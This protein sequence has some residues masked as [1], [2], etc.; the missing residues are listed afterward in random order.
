[1]YMLIAPPVRFRGR[2]LSTQ[3]VGELEV[4]DACVRKH[5][6][7]LPEKVQSFAPTLYGLGHDGIGESDTWWWVVVSLSNVD[8]IEDARTRSRMTSTRVRQ[9]RLMRR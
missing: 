5:H 2:T 1:M 6:L 9:A 4:E 8:Q 3:L 7:F